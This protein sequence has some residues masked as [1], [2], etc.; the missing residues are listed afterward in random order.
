MP[1][2]RSSRGCSMLGGMD[3]YDANW[4]ELK[5]RRNQWLFAFIG[6]IPITFLFGLLTYS[7]FHSEKPVFVFAIA[8]MLF[9]VVAGNRYGHFH[10]PRC[11]KWFFATWWYHNTFA[12]RCVHC[13]LPLWSTKEQTTGRAQTNMPYKPM[14]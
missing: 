14:G 13:K 10:C 7:L 8:W 3:E 12:R 4:Q 2:V 1:T 5:R 6:Y 9:F 11:G